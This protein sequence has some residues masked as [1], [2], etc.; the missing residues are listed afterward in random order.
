MQ[1]KHCFIQFKLVRLCI[2]HQMPM[3]TTL[4]VL[5]TTHYICWKNWLHWNI[6]K[7]PIKT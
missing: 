4:L 2:F 5:Q 6:N 7:V 1:L 3:D